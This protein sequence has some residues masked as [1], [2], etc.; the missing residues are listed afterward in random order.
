[1]VERPALVPLTTF[2]ASHAFANPLISPTGHYVAVRAELDGRELVSVIDLELR[3][4]ATMARLTKEQ[5]YEWHRWAGPTT[6]LI[7][8]SQP[9][10]V[11][12]EELRLTRLV[13]LDVATKRH[14]IIGP[15]RMGIEGDNLLHVAKDGS[16]IL[17]AYQKS[18]Y[19]WPSVYRISLGDPNA[20]G[21]LVQRPVKGIWNWYADDAGV[22]RMGTGWM[23]RKLRVTYR[24]SAAERFREIARLGEGDYEEF[25]NVVHIISGSDEGYVLDE[26]EDGRVSLKRFNYATREPIETIY[27]NDEWDL[28]DGW[29]DENGKPLAVDFVDDRDRRVWLDPEMAKLQ[30]DFEKALGVDEVWIGSRSDDGGRMLVSAGGETDPGVLYVYDAS[31]RHLDAFGEF[32]PELDI[33]LLARPRPVTYVARDGTKIAAYLTLPKGR[34]PK[35]LPLII[36]PHGGPF[37]VRDKLTYDDDVQV[38]ANRGYAILQPNF[39]GSDGYGSKFEELGFGQIG[40][41]MQD[42]LDDAMDWAV[43]QGIADAGRVCVVGASYG[44][45][46]AMWAVVRNPERYRCAASFAGVSDWKKQLRYDANFF[47]RKGRRK[48]QDRVRGKEEFNLDLV[49]PAHT[50]YRLERPLLVAHGEEDSSVPFS[51][52]QLVHKAAQLAGVPIEV[53][54]FEDEGHGFTNPANKTK[55]YAKLT[56]F[57]A[58]H[59]PAD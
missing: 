17:L 7:S 52:F 43:A 3:R 30:R 38:L 10:R 11:L 48:W 32:R 19:D 53:L 40:R 55:W 31:T 25:W 5:S 4:P 54:I 28:V 44:G 41:A 47:S 49:S 16:S 59:N 35:K 27:R 13:A 37:G 20:K 18:I 57:L 23:R 22:V 45:Y 29:L 14:W 26:D 58:K 6:V 1:M 42:D 46:A 15:S 51:Q 9:S 12:G 33:S 8:I 36:L 2:A 50:I 34:I 56:E 39:R 24:K 21:E